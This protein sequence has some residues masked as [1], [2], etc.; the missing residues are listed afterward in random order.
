MEQNRE[1]R[2]KP[3]SLCQLI[4]NKGVR[5]IK[6]SKNSPFN[7]WCWE[8]WTATCK[9]TKLDHLC[10]LFNWVV[11]GPGVESCEPFYILDFKPL[12][13][14]SLA[15]VFFHTVGSLLI[16]LMFSLDIQ[17]LFILM[18]SHLFILRKGFQKQKNGVKKRHILA[19]NT[20]F[21]A[22]SWSWRERKESIHQIFS[23]VLTR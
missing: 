16:F 18:K 21:Q 22:R 23:Q 20:L 12:S 13:D 11:C 6:W 15:N 4:F 2:N 10:P 1:P 17:K 14:V 3:K 19:K 7:K 8:I 9:K 5:S